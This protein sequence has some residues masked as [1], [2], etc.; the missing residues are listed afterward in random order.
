MID[1]C[2]LSKMK[3]ESKSDLTY[4]VNLSYFGFAKNCRNLTTYGFELVTSSD[5][6][7]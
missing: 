1:E 5:T 7:I 3:A 2:G 6:V 4:F